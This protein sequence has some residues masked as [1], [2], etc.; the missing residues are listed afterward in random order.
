MAAMDISERRLPQDG[1][2]HVMLEG[3]KID[4]RVSTCP[5]NRGEKTVIR[6]LDTRSVSLNLE[7]LGFAEDILTSLQQSDP[8][9]QRHHPR[10]R[11]DRQR[12]IDHALRRAERDQLDGQQHLHGRRPDR[13]SSAV[14]QPVPSA[15][16]SR[17]DILRRCCE[18]CCGRIPT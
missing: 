1:R 10:H 15:G 7:D 14:D 13:I 18:R 11:P 4:L 12:Q 5:T 17:P 3:R 9:A 16:E 6:V 2:V 8:V